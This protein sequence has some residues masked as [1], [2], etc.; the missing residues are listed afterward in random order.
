MPEQIKKLS[1]KEKNQLIIQMINEGTSSEIKYYLSKELDESQLLKASYEQTL[2]QVLLAR[3]LSFHGATIS[4]IRIANKVIQ[5]KLSNNQF[6]DEELSK[7]YYQI[8][9]VY[10]ELYSDRGIDELYIRY[11]LNNKKTNEF[12]L[13]LKLIYYQSQISSGKKEYNLAM[14]NKFKHISK[15]PPLSPLIEYSVKHFTICNLIYSSEPDFKNILKQLETLSRSAPASF[16]TD[17]LLLKKKIYIN[18]KRKQ[19]Q[20]L[21][22]EK[23]GKNL[24]HVIEN[25]F[26]DKFYYKQKL[27][28]ADEVSLRCYPAFNEYSFLL[29]NRFYSNN[30]KLSK[31][32]LQH[33]NSV[34][35]F[36]DKSATDHWLIDNNTITNSQS[37]Y[38]EEKLNILNLATGLYVNSF[39]KVIFLGEKN[40]SL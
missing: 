15:P 16:V 20:Y 6:T 19:K 32:F 22:I 9:V 3:F 38:G 37:T 26:L 14:E 17:L 30:F 7:L 29:G 12:S 34:E 2:H 18:L 4:P 1:L 21:D 35:S 5:N 23:N 33:L 31:N 10:F 36:R 13:F 8:A 25:L 24:Y 39:G 27:Q 40:L 28:L 11:S